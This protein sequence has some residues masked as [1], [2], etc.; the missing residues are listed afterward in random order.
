M[1]T[2]QE[3]LE[4]VL[5]T[6][7]M[8]VNDEPKTSEDLSTVKPEVSYDFNFE[9]QTVSQP[10][11]NQTSETATVAPAAVPDPAIGQVNPNPVVP[12]NIV[13]IDVDTAA[14]ATIVKPVV[15]PVA[16][17]VVQTNIKTSGTATEEEIIIDATKGT[18]EVL[19]EYAITMDAAAE[20]A[21]NKKNDI[22]IAVV[23]GVIIL[24]IVL[25]RVIIRIVGY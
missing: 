1:E 8:P 13:P 22:F 6:A 24:F 21:K 14:G 9:N 18:A 20:K 10:V 19:D 17:P 12:E 11:T 5:P 3:G 4:P 2:K 15:K 23:F 16:A 25:L 7:V